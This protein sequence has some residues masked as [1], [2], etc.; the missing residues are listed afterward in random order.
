MSLWLAFTFIHWLSG[1]CLQFWCNHISQFYDIPMG[2]VQ[3]LWCIWCN[4]SI[5]WNHKVILLYFHLNV[6]KFCLPCLGVCFVWNLCVWCSDSTG[7]DC[8][9]L[10]FPLH[11]SPPFQCHVC[12]W[13][14]CVYM[15]NYFWAPCLFNICNYLSYANV[16][17]L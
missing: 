17:L 4:S 12:S 15:W 7:F 8:V 11:L 13:Q 14:V 6:V 16:T 3:G 5:P 10:I 9:A 2:E 1:E